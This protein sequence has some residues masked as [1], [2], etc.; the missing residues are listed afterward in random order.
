MNQSSTLAMTRSNLRDKVEIRIISL[1]GSLAGMSVCNLCTVL[2]HSAAFEPG[3]VGLASNTCPWICTTGYYYSAAA[4][5]GTTATP[6][7][8][9]CSNAPARASYTGSGAANNSCPWL[10]TAGNYPSDGVCLPCPAGKYSKTAGKHS[11]PILLLVS[12]GD[13]DG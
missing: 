4:V 1:M 13:V 9:L 8:V 10:C 2:P 6:A 5:T 11:H 12:P 3:I 7:C